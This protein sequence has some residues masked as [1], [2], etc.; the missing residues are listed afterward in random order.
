[1]HALIEQQQHMTMPAGGTRWRAAVSSSE[2]N[3]TRHS[4]SEKLELSCCFRRW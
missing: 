4:R 2:A 3:E 1:M